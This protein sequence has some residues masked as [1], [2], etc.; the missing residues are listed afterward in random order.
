MTIKR[1][2]GPKAVAQSIIK[3]KEFSTVTFFDEA[4]KRQVVIL[5]SLGEDGIVREYSN[6]KWTAFPITEEV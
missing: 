5:Y 1:N 2:N 6:G 4:Q 3:A